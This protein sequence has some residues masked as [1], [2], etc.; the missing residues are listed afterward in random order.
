VRAAVITRER[1]MVVADRWDVQ[2]HCTARAVSWELSKITDR[3]TWQNERLRNARSVL[4]R[5]LG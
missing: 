1:L 3:N 2:A 4:K 5:K